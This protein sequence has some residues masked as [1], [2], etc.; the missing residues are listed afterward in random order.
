VNKKKKK[1]EKT[2]VIV[3]GQLMDPVRV[4]I[5]I[6]RV[7]KKTMTYGKRKKKLVAAFLFFF[8]LSASVE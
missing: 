5:R 7:E 8:V 3:Q 1:N 2:V 6:L 4:H